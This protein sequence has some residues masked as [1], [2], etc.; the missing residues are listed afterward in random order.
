M[1]QLADPPFPSMAVEFCTRWL[2]ADH[3]STFWPDRAGRHFRMLSEHGGYVSP[4]TPTTYFTNFLATLGARQIASE[5]DRFVM[6]EDRFEY[7]EAV[8]AI[9]EH[10]W[11]EATRN[12]PI[13]EHPNLSRF[14][15]EFDDILHVGDALITKDMDLVSEVLK[16]FLRVSEQDHSLAYPCSSTQPSTSTTCVRKRTLRSG[17]TRRT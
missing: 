11:E 1:D 8:D 16:L 13:L 7:R 5:F 12:L 17:I 14:E 10:M 6:E 9:I 2:E 4:N 15:Y 3:S